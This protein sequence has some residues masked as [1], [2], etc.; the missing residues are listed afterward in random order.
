MSAPP[1]PL[2]YVVVIAIV[3]CGGC[4]SAVGAAGSDSHSSSGALLSLPT[5]AVYLQVC[6][7][8]SVVFSRSTKQ[9]CVVITW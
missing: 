7:V 6:L 4:A 1:T 9:A 8:Q 5:G 3:L 2:E